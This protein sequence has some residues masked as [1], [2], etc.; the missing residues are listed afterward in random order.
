[1][2]KLHIFGFEARAQQILQCKINE[3]Q[4]LGD[5]DGKDFVY[6]L[7]KNICRIALFTCNN[8]FS[9]FNMIVVLSVFSLVAINLHKR[10]NWETTKTLQDFHQ[11]SIM[12]YMAIF[13]QGEAG[14]HSTSCKYG[15]ILF[16]T[17]SFPLFSRFSLGQFPRMPP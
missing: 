6:F 16:L 9:C 1:M 5:S 7:P 17:N 13:F 10:N 4:K 12:S 3:N 11:T 8:A 2:N 14:F 15:N